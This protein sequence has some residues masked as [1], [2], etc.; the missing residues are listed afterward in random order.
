M[1]TASTGGKFGSSDFIAPHRTRP[2]KKIILSN[3]P[4]GQAIDGFGT[5]VLNLS[6]S[7][8]HLE[9]L[10]MDKLTN[11]MCEFIEG[12][13]Q[14]KAIGNGESHFVQLSDSL[15][16]CTPNEDGLESWFDMLHC[17]VPL[18]FMEELAQRLMSTYEIDVSVVD[19]K[20]G[21][22]VLQRET[23]E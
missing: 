4:T 23:K 15:V 5:H 3:A 13:A 17:Y 8:P 21:G 22:L 18:T 11:L 12:K 16:E 6:N 7:E 14:I 9:Q 1:G 2:L 19:G 20:D 10:L